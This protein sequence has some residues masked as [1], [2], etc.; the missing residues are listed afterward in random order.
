MSPEFV[1]RL[2]T[3]PMLLLLSS[4]ATPSFTVQESSL[5]HAN[6]WQKGDTGTYWDD[7]N[8]AILVSEGVPASWF[9]LA[10]RGWFLTTSQTIQAENLRSAQINGGVWK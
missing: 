5:V 10:S 8:K 1:A 4:C 7:S 6:P 9:A 2:F 3:L